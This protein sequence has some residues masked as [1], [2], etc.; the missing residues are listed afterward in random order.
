VPRNLCQALAVGDES[1]CATRRNGRMSRLQ[2]LFLLIFFLGLFHLL[3]RTASHIQT[4]AAGSLRKHQ[5]GRL[6]KDQ[7]LPIDFA[8][9]LGIH[10]RLVLV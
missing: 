10:F 2:S 6:A 8:E 1:S 5:R 9:P 7:D 4:H 3:R